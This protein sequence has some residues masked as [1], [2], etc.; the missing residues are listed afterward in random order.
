MYF[1][2]FCG[3][4]N[5]HCQTTGNAGVVLS[6]KF[7]KQLLH[8]F[9]PESSLLQKQ[10]S[11]QSVA[12]ICYISAILYIT[13]N[14]PSQNDNLPRRWRHLTPPKHQQIS[15]RLHGITSQKAVTFIL[16]AAIHNT[17]ACLKT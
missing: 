8:L 7:L 15:L 12:Q 13:A 16:T 2:Y 17:D 3:N 11:L 10:Y 6:A 1:L 14:L 9:C 4:K 5:V